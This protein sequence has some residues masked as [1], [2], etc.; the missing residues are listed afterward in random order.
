MGTRIK[1][2]LR[3]TVPARCI[4]LDPDATEGATF[5]KNI[6]AP[7]G[8]LVDLADLLNGAGDGEE[9]PFVYWRQLLEVPPNVVALATINTVGIYAITATGAS[10]TREIQATIGRTTVANGDGVAGDPV[11][12]LAVVPNSGVGAAL[13]KVTI[14]TFGRTTGTE[15][16]TTDDLAEGAAN[17]YFTNLRAQDAVGAILTD[18]GNVLLT[19][20]GGPTINASLS[21][22]VLSALT[23][24]TT[25]VQ[26]VQPG[27]NVTIDNTDPQNPIVN[28]TGTGGFPVMD[29][30]ADPS[31]MTAA[32]IYATLVDVLAELQSTG[33]M[34]G[35]PP[36]VPVNT[37]PPAITGGSTSGDVL[38][39]SNGTWTESPTSYAYQWQELIAAVWTDLVG[40]TANTYTTDHDGD[41][42]GQ[43]I[44]TNGVGDGLPA[45][46]ATHAIGVLFGFVGDMG[47]GGAGNWPTSGDRGLGCPF[48]LADNATLTSFNMRTT[49]ANNAGDKFRGLLYAADGPGGY[50][51][52][53]LCETVASATAIAGAQVINIAIPPASPI[54]PQPVWIFYVA[55]GGSS[56]FGG[57]ETDSGGTNASETI[58]LNGTLSFAAPQDP[59]PTWPGSPGPYANVPAVWFEYTY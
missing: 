5:G 10:A 27:T 17:F 32:D 28:A 34:D 26:S 25:A 43:V 48:V 2:L 36:A 40:E 37:V 59:C 6:Y 38:T 55:D 20:A 42:R 41:F 54:P 45:Y 8:V 12:D 21:A 47:S 35:P 57:G 22:A 15:A 39:L 7:N 1:I 31:T 16:A 9:F 52:T 56:A 51:G 4:T 13:V 46:S 11:V 50:A 14:D 29:Y 33:R 24:A 58:M 44:A 18:D 19:Y 3:D 30:I 53:L 23:L 49:S